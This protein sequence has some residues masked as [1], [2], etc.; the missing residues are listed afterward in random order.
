[1]TKHTNN[2]VELDAEDAYAKALADTKRA[3]AERD[4]AQ[5]EVNTLQRQVYEAEQR[6][7]ARETAADD[8]AALAFLDGKS[9][10]AADATLRQ[11]LD[12]A[13]ARLAVLER[14]T[15]IAR[16]RMHAARRRLDN[17]AAKSAQPRHAE[18]VKRIATALVDLAL[19]LEEETAIRGELHNA[20]ALP[21]MTFA[22]VGT[23][24]AI[25]SNVSMWLKRAEGLGFIEPGFRAD[26]IAPRRQALRDAARAASARAWE[27]Q[28]RSESTAAPKD[29]RS[30]IAEAARK[31]A[32][33]G[34]AAE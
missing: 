27:H 18:A 31:L 19:A 26:D 9:V 10:P 15:A 30:K 25:D 20:L 24:A 12:D 23:L 5:A 1:M 7:D 3:R 14:A 34:A 22:G 13:C 17:A 29:T 33:L 6:T 8:A 16:E 32:S 4:A 11:R 21:P 2:V 28:P